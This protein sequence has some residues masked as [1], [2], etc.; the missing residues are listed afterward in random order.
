MHRRETTYNLD[1]PIM[2]LQVQNTK[3]K[4]VSEG[5]LI[6]VKSVWAERK[7]G[8]GGEQFDEKIFTEDTREYIIRFDP[9]IASLLQETLVVQEEGKKLLRI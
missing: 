5:S 1:R 9:D 6:N 4:G 8:S 3:N 2:I 7:E